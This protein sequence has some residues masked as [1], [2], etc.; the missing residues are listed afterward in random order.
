M[1]LGSCTGEGGGEERSQTLKKKEVEPLESSPWGWGPGGGQRA[2]AETRVDAGSNLRHGQGAL[3]HGL[4]RLLVPPQLLQGAGLAVQ[5]SVVPL[6][7][8][9][10]LVAV[11][12]GL[13]V[14]TLKRTRGRHRPAVIPQGRTGTRAKDSLRECSGISNTKGARSTEPG[15]R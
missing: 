7:Q 14:E 8:L 5:G 1:T 9:Q 15:K 10:G 4:V 12:Q 6:V 2:W 13:V 11:L 3:G